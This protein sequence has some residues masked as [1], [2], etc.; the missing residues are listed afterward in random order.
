MSCKLGFTCKWNFLH[1]HLYQI[2]GQ[3]QYTRKMHQW[4]CLKKPL[5]P[6]VIKSNVSNHFTKVSPTSSA[7]LLLLVVPKSPRPSMHTCE[8][9]CSL[10][11]SPF[12]H[13][14]MPFGRIRCMMNG[15]AHAA[16]FVSVYCTCSTFMYKNMFMYHCLCSR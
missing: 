11:C 5:K 14:K 16:C 4:D 1:A 8:N 13:E 7:M 15:L 12:K 2:K 10:C 3:P 9:F 6:P